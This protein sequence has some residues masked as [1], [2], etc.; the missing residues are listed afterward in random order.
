MN[1]KHH[2]TEDTYQTGRTAPPK[3]YQGIIAFLLVL[4]IFLCGIST[5]LGLLNIHLFRKLRQQPETQD[6]GLSFSQ[7]EYQQTLPQSD[8]VC[9][10]P[11]GLSGEEVSAFW[12]QYLELPGGI[13]ITEVTA[14]AAQVGLQPGDI[15]VG[16]DQT[17]VLTVQ[18]LNA[19]LDRCSTGDVATLL[20]YRDGQQ[21]SVRLPIQ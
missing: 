13:Y 12:Q 14:T 5:A 19:L 1:E 21:R 9:F 7:G 17:Q 20:I 10:A 18:T 4:V 11:L 15:L 6:S 2:P 3:S 16:F 8:P